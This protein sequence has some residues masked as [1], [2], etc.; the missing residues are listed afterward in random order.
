MGKPE[1]RYRNKGDPK[2]E[3]KQCT[4]PKARKKGFAVVS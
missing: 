1:L 3:Q 4:V 2:P